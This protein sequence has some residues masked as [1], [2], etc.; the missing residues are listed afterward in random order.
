MNTMA[1]KIEINKAINAIRRQRCIKYTMSGVM[2]YSCMSTFKYQAW[3]K[4]LKIVEKNELK[5]CYDS[6]KVNKFSSIVFS[7]YVTYHFA[8]WQL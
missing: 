5:N 7:C 2:I 4:L 3:E 8:A 1:P 6:G